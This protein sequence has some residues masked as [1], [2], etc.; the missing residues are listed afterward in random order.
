M[1]P[2]IE[3]TYTLL[4]S[5]KAVDLYEVEILG[6]VFYEIRHKNHD[7]INREYNYL[8]ALKTFNQYAI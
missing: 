8:S 5:N 3:R 1:Y 6:M 7:R 2:N 4:K